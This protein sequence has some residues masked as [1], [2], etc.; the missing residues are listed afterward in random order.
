MVNFVDGTV[1]TAA[2]LNSFQDKLNDIVSVKDFGAKGD[3]VTDDTVAIQAALN[4]GSSRIHIPQGTYVISNIVI[5]G[6][7]REFIG[8]GSTNTD[9]YLLRK[10]G[11]T[12]AAISWNGSNRVTQAFIGHFR[13]DGNSGVGETYGMDLSGFSYC[14]FENI[15]V[16]AFTLDGIYENG[17]ITP[18]NQQFSNNVFTNVRSTN[19]LRDGW[20]FENTTNSN[21]ANT[22]VTCE[23]SGNAGVGF[24]ELFGNSNRVVGGTFQGNTGRDFY[25]NAT[26]G[27]YDFYMEGNTLGCEMGSSSFGNEISC[28]SSFPAWNTFVDSGT[29][30]RKRI[31]GSSGIIEH[32]YNDP[33]TYNWVQSSVPS[34]IGGL[35]T[36]AYSSAADT[37]SPQNYDLVLTLGSNTSGIRLFPNRTVAQ[38]S[39][40]WVTLVLEVDTSGV[41][42]TPQ[43]RIYTNIDDSSNTNTGEFVAQNLVITGSGTTQKMFFDVKF[44]S[45]TGTTP[46][47]YCYLIYSGYVSSSVIK[48]KSINILSGQILENSPL[49]PADPVPSVQASLIGLATVGLNVHRKYAG[50]L[51]F[52]TTANKLRYAI[53]SNTTSAWR[54]V[55]G[56]GDIT[57]A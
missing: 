38:L 26:K 44:A 34:N 41:V 48:V 36:V 22:Y 8:Y 21:S 5:P 1:L 7:C 17:A 15:W 45:T 47:L 39:G 9:T 25:T 12:G 14:T 57:P 43:V 29:Q 50:R 56:S 40:K 13:L 51:V 27:I 16:R 30:N 37:Q 31:R 32:I 10:N 11:S 20:R 35:G 23:G 3:G 18:V 49:T 54:A 53:G 24:N 52:D 33:Y 55:D 4:S 19:N 6:N 42:G 46:A 28:R 2:Q